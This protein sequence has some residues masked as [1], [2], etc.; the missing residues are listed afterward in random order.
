[1]AVVRAAGGVPAAGV[2]VGRLVK[3]REAAKVIAVVS[4]L[5]VAIS[6]MGG[7][8]VGWGSALAPR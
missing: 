5:D 3:L 1:M 7:V 6:T 2:A 8:G 4:L